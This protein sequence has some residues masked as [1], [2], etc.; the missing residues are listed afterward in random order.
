MRIPPEEIRY[1]PLSL[2]D[3]GV[4]F[5]WRGKLYR[6]IPPQ[7]VELIRQLFGSG[8]I[9]ALV[10]QRMFVPSRVTDLELDG[11]GLIVEHEQIRTVT[12]P[13]E[14]TFSMLRD[15]GL[16][17]V[18]LNELASRYGFQTQDCHCYNVLFSGEAPRYVDLGSFTRSSAR[19]LLSRDEFLRSYCYP[20]KIWRS[21]GPVWGR[22][23]IQRPGF[24]LGTEDYL[25]A[26]WPIFRWP[27]A[28]TVG[29]MLARMSRL[30]SLSDGAFDDFRGRH[31]AWK[32][33]LAALVRD[34]GRR[35]AAFSRMRSALNAIE[36]GRVR[37]A[38]SDYHDPLAGRRQDA[39]LTPRFRHVADR[40]ASLEVSS[41]LEIAAN[42][43]ILSRAL[44]R[45]RPE[46]PVIS[47]D[48]DEAALDKGYRASLSQG[49]GVDWA[50]HD[51]FFTELSNVEEAPETR[52]RSEAV[53]ALALTHHLVLTSGLSLD[54]VLHVL[55][56]YS[57][58]YVLV[59]FMP[60]G[61]FDGTRPA[62]VP[63]WYTTEWFQSGF[64]KRFKL[65]ERAKLEENR[66]LFVGR[67]NELE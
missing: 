15:A 56:L 50:V 28:S 65:I 55:S 23:A 44:K 63:A 7:R 11:Y 39:E 38:W 54:R 5:R 48:R 29:R 3:A 22:Q 2:M 13:R 64:E 6:A 47:T 37:T 42:Q 35:Q 30:Q 62:A 21:L 52:F 46:L 16:L 17:I 58:R 31:P 18:R 26:R 67:K 66:I 27:G 32:V 45:A 10:E 53:V 60:L 40:L 9:D 8:L 59:E 41:V 51:P 24:L 49:L 34:S 25:A 19:G 61:L 57:S 14:W 36:R 33:T 20:L 1:S 4:V 43:G 12:Y